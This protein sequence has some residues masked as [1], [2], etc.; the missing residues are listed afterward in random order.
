MEISLDRRKRILATDSVICKV[1]LSEL[2]IENNLCGKFSLFPS[3][4]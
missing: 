3:Y 1:D 4:E 2:F